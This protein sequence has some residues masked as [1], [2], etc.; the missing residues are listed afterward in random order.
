MTAAKN[1]VTFNPDSHLAGYYNN[2]V[3]SGMKKMDARKRVARA[4]V[5][6]L[7]KDLYSLIDF[8]SANVIDEKRD[9]SDM[10]NGSSRCDWD[11]SN[12]PSPSHIIQH[13][14]CVEKIKK[15]RSMT[16]TNDKA[17]IVGGKRKKSE[18]I[19]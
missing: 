18:E 13:T 5:R 6:V 15:E 11:H 2:L 12:I 19:A 3:K 1:V 9:G 10:A 17:V 8:N 16:T 4:L 7:F 14:E